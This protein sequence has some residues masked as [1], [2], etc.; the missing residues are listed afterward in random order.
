MTSL[1]ALFLAAV[2]SA[3]VYIV[4]GPIMQLIRWLRAGPDGGSDPFQ[5][6]Q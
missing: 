1:Q 5:D 4:S 6:F 3:G 2:L